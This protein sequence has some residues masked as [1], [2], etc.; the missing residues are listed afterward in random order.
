MVIAAV[1]PVAESEVAAT[2]EVPSVAG[3]GRGSAGRTKA[4]GETGV[5]DNGV[6]E[7]QTSILLLTK[8]VPYQEMVFVPLAS[9][10]R[11]R[12]LPPRRR[13]SGPAEGD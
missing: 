13:R 1:A 11:I 9:L 12:I 3:E 4:G 8:V 5:G 2:G 6:P 7:G 10:R